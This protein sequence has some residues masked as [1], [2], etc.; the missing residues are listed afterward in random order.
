M[1]FSYTCFLIGLSKQEQRQK[2]VIWNSR[3]QKENFGDVFFFLPSLENSLISC[4]MTVIVF[5][6]H[7]INAEMICEDRVVTS[8]LVWK[9]P[10]DWHHMPV[11][12][13]K[14]S[15]SLGGRVRD[16]G[17]DGVTK[18]SSCWLT[19]LHISLTENI[20]SVWTHDHKG[21]TDKIRK[22]WSLQWS[23]KHLLWN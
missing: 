18:Q 9:P 10:D 16:F 20:Q 11:L 6:T 23:W 14:G 15:F 8:S 17:G 22:N 12:P 13:E 19:L 1:L 2:W 21:T 3:Y 4:Q 5:A 7:E